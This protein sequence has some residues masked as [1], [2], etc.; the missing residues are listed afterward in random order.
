MVNRESNNNMVSKELN[1]NMVNKE[2]NNNMV[3]KELNNKMV[4]KDLNS[5]NLGNKSLYLNNNSKDLDKQLLS[6][7]EVL[8]L[9]KLQKVKNLSRNQ[10]K[11]VN[12]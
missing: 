2:L 12:E 5:N 10:K 1:N 8:D 3:N 11:I 9:K 7:W 4:I 6:Y